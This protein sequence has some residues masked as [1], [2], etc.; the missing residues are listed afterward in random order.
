MKARLIERRNEEMMLAYPENG[1]VV[2]KAHRG[3]FNYLFGAGEIGATERVPQ[4]VFST[5][6]S[7]TTSKRT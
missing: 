2:L 5:G 3:R 1:K 7:Y 4:K 6:L